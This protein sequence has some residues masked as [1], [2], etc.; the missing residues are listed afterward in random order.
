MGGRLENKVALIT[1]GAS[2]IGEAQARLFTSEGASVVIADLQMEKAEHVIADIQAAGG[3]AAFARLD[4]REHEQWTEVV[5]VVER[6]FG[7]LDILCNNAGTNHRV[8]F[9]DL[10]IKQYRNV[11]EVNLNG[12]YL[13]CRAAEAALKRAGGG[14]ILNIGSL[15]SHKHG[16]STGYTVSKTAIIA[17]TKNVALGL[18]S[19]GTRC[20][21]VCPGHVDTPFIRGNEAHSRNDWSTSLENPDNYSRRL[22]GTPLG[23]LQTG[24]DIA[25]AALFLCSD[26]AE[27][28]R[29]QV[30]VVDGGISLVGL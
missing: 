6:T 5:A 18:A 1:G 10:T 14:A 13:G 30:V 9:N 17:L 15:A 3:E 7:R 22:A 21:A 29:G 12:A 26:E 11:I 2:G 25:K 27:M 20:N 4:V 19:Q 8:S 24:D 23:R 28:I 16:G